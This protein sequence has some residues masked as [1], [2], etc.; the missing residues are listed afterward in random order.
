[1]FTLLWIY[2][3]ILMF[4]LV[5]DRIGLAK[6][7]WF[8]KFCVMVALVIFWPLLPLMVLVAENLTVA[9]VLNSIKNKFNKIKE[10]F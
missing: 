8:E 2:A 3:G 1:M 7:Q 4:A 6:E 9:D 10:Q 5:R